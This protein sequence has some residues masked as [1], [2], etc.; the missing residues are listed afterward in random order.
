MIG[1]S[2]PYIYGDERE[3]VQDAFEKNEIAIGSYLGYFKQEILNFT[4]A[5]GCVLTS[6]GTAALHLSLIALGVRPNDE[7]I[8]PTLTFIATIN[9]IKY[10]NASPIFLIVI[11]I[12]I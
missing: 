11:I 6:S 9:A 2:V 1:L 5:E 12:Q 3:F 8:A 10:V 7:V 4:K